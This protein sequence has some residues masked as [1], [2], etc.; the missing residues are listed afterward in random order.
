MTVTTSVNGLGGTTS[1]EH[2]IRKNRTKAF[3][4]ALLATD[5]STDVNIAASDN[6]RVKIVRGNEA[7]PD[8]EI[9]SAADTANGSG[10]AFTAGTND[11]VLTIAQDDSNGLNLGVYEMEVN[12]I[13]DSDSDYIKYAER[14]VLHVLQSGGGDVDL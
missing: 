4:F 3:N 13:D 8:L 10:I 1:F 6:V 5:G 12:L 7:T 2:V 11:F 14:G 9:E